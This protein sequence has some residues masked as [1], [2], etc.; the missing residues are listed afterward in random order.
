MIYKQGYL[1]IDKA[2]LSIDWKTR[3]YG[4]RAMDFKPHLIK[5]LILKDCEVGY[6]MHRLFQYLF[7]KIHIY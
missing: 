3:C 1:I 5:G 7:H 6:A 4:N 2:R